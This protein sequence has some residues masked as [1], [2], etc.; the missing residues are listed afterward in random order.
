MVMQV[1]SGS[2]TQFSDT[3]VVFIDS[4]AARDVWRA[5]GV[6]EDAPIH[7][8][9]ERMRSA[10]REISSSFASALS[11]GI[12]DEAAVNLVPCGP[13]G[14]LPLHLLEIPAG[15]GTSR[16]LID[17]YQITYSLSGAPSDEVAQ[18]VESDENGILPAA[19]VIVDQA[20]NLRFAAIEGS[21]VSGHF[22]GCTT[23]SANPTPATVLSELAGKT[24]IHFACHGSFNQAKPYSSGLH[25]ADGVLTVSSLLD[26]SPAPLR[27]AELVVLSSCESAVAD[28]TA[29]DEAIGLPAAFVGCRLDFRGWDHVAGRRLGHS[30]VDV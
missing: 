1:N 29:P 20:S 24:L 8:P 22:P 12:P 9:A 7:L 19:L 26:A 21:I 14:L 6:G 28:P 3:S 16:Q 4:I 23:L 17:K 10:V 2:A 13:L 15:E 5:L 27:S 30:S 25:L 11:V 18:L